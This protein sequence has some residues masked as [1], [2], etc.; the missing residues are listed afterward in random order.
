METQKTEPR[1]RD[2]LFAV[3]RRDDGRLEAWAWRQARIAWR[4][5]WFIAIATVAV[6]VVATVVLLL[7]PNEYRASARVLSPESGGLNPLSAVLGRNLSTAASSLLGGGTGEYARYLTLLTSRS[8]RETVVD[9]FDLVAAY[10]TDDA[11]FPREAAIQELAERTSFPVDLEFEFL[12]IS[13]LDR[14]PQRAAA[15]AN[16]MV[17]ELNRRNAALASQSASSFYQYVQ[18]RYNQALAD[19]DSLLDASQQFQQQYG[20]YNVDAQTQ[21]FFTQMGDLSADLARQQIEYER[22]RAQYGAGNPQVQSFE[23]ALA[24]ARRR[25]Q[26]A[27]GGSE[28]LLPVA[29]RNMP[30]VV[31]QYVALERDLTVQKSMLEVIAPMLETARLQEEQQSEALQVVDRA[32][33]PVKK[34]WP[35]RSMLLIS[36]VLSTFVLALLVALFHAAWRQHA[37]ALRARL[38]ADGPFH[39]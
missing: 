10:E 38:R 18:R 12:S 36:I 34:D 6:A 4:R 35:R 39:E 25:Y 19:V 1:L 32:V 15:M 31:R 27:M 23:T 20:V 21:A 16:F 26:Q 11:K 33:P 8:M 28:D 22:L 5:R 24:A 14:D 9:T 17:A 3:D 7:I 37:P 29:Q 2:E 13:V 30:A